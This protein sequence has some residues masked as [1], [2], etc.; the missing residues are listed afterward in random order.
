[1]GS[2]RPTATYHVLRL[3]ADDLETLHRRLPVWNSREYRRRLLAQERGELVEAIA[4]FG[5]VPGGRG[6]V[7]FPE[8][9]EFSTSAVREGCAEVRDVF[10]ARPRRRLGVA[11]A[12]M[13]ALEDAV[14]ERGM[15]RVGLSVSLDEEAAPARVLYER[16]GYVHAHGPFVSSTDLL[17]EDGPVAV[18]AV[19]NYLVKEL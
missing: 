3:A 16:L 12:L 14:A 1:M 15:A 11:T 13:R 6:M 2:T 5:D 4:W 7:L 8:H 19:M 17:R 18:G 9:D 10:V